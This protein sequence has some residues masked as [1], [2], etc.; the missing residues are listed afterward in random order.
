MWRPSWLWTISY[1]RTRTAW[2]WWAAGSIAAAIP[3]LPWLWY[4]AMADHAGEQASAALFAWWRPFTAR[5]WLAWATEPFGLG[6]E[7][8]LGP[9]FYALLRQPVVGGYATF[10]VAALQGVS[11]LLGLSMLSRAGLQ[12][13]NDRARWRERWRAGQGVYTDAVLQAGFWFF[14]I[15][16]TV[17]CLRFERHYLAVAYPLLMLWTARLALA[18]GATER[19]ARTGRTLLATLVATNALTS[20]ALLA[21]IHVN[22]GAPDGD[23][24]KSYARQLQ[25]AGSGLAP[26]G[27]R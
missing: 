23:Y 7:Y 10:G 24:S 9:D 20:M 1:D 12:A 15:I 27:N 8:F 4:M 14:G 11:I 21:F 22:G 16:L 3:M 2:K 18:S 25:E 26:R 6:L 17:S 5:F 13:W 19:E